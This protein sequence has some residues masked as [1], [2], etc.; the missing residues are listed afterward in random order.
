[1]LLSI[2][3]SVPREDEIFKQSSNILSDFD[4]CCQPGD[5]IHDTIVLLDF[6]P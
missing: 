5:D 2:F 3:E 1:M 6:E 4:F